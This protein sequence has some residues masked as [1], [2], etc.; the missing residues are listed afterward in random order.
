MAEEDFY[1]WFHRLLLIG[2]VIAF[3]Y[4]N[5]GHTF[6]GI[7]HLFVTA[8][9][10]FLSEISDDQAE[11]IAKT[12]IAFGRTVGNA[13]TFGL[14]YLAGR[15]VGEWSDYSFNRNTRQARLV[16]L[17]HKSMM[18]ALEDSRSEIG[19]LQDMI[20]TIVNM[21]T[22]LEKHY[23]QLQMIRT[24]SDKIKS[25]PKTHASEPQSTHCN[26]AAAEPDLFSATKANGKSRKPPRRALPMPKF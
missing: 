9:T 4:F 20:E 26:G 25:K 14:F 15:W 17:E 5:R 2:C 22:Q 21:R 8:R 13:V 11:F 23:D 1:I 10:S 3:L 7:A 6:D 16:E 19:E 24:E 18:T 12:T